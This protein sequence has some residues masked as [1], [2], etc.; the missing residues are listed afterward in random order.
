MLKGIATLL[1]ICYLVPGCR[2][3]GSTTSDKTDTTQ[4][5]PLKNI[6][7]EDSTTKKDLTGTHHVDSLFPGSD[8]VIAEKH[9]GGFSEKPA[10]SFLVTSGKMIHA[11]IIPENDTANLRI[12]Q[13]EMPDSTF[14]GPFGREIHYKMNIPG[15]Y[16]LIVGESMMAEGEWT[17]DFKIKIWVN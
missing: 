13:I 17:G 1:L 3:Q 2:E 8:T 7:G 16:K 4:N 6:S 10:V 15:V 5:L 12:N 14:D 11:I 9:I